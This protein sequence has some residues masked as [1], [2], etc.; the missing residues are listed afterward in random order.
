ME[1]GSFVFR[2]MRVVVPGS[3]SLTFSMAVGVMVGLRMVGI[4]HIQNYSSW[5]RTFC[6]QHL[7]QTLR[8]LSFWERKM[9]NRFEHGLLQKWHSLT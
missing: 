3:A 9:A 7:E 2:W 5:G 6:F 4:G 1:M 8:I